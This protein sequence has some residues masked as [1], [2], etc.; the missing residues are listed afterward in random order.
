MAQLGIDFG[1]SNTA[2]AVMAGDA[3]FVIPLEGGNTT[4]PTAVFFD[5]LARKTQFGHAALRALVDGRDGRFMRALKSVLGTPLMHERRGIQHERLTLI[6]VVARFLEQVRKAAESQTGLAFD[7]VV[8]G[9]PVRFHP[10]SDRDARAQADLAQCYEMAGF[11]QVSFV[12]EPEAASLASGGVAAGYGLIVDIGGGTSDFSVFRG[13]PGKIEVLANHGI[14]LGGTDFDR[15][16]SLAAVMPM[17]GLGSQIK[18]LFGPALHDAP[19]AIFHDLATWEKIPFLYT[20][21]TR[22]GVDDMARLAVEPQLFRRLQSVL[23]HELG[24]D[25]ALAVET[26]KIA[27]NRSGDGRVDLR[28]VEAGLAAPISGAVLGAELGPSATVIGENAMTAVEAAGIDPSDV[29]KVVMVGGSSL[30]TVVEADIRA[31]LPRAAIERSEAFTA[32]VA[33]LAIA[34]GRAV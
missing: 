14:R 9:R 4:Q 12:P 21:S 26:A 5:G 7:G 30:L 8:S 31:R 19:Q 6:E 33:G 13:T 32:V 20:Q 34:A 15:M 16:L 17:M 24:H 11:S 29:T 1:T 18:A 22:R 10:D 25:V 27:A 3:P 2:A 28:L 23:E